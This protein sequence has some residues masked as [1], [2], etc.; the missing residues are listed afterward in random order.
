MLE[1]FKFEIMK[2]C[3]GFSNFDKFGRDFGLYWIL[4]ICVVIREN[5]TIVDVAKFDVNIFDAT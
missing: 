4:L 5:E 2:N 1:L 3:G